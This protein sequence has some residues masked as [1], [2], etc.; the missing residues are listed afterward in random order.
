[1]IKATS[2]KIVLMKF[3]KASRERLVFSPS[4]R[5]CPTLLVSEA[6]SL[7]TRSTKESF[8]RKTIGTAASCSALIMPLK[9]LFVLFLELLVMFFLQLFVHLG[10]TIFVDTNSFKNIDPSPLH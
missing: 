9:V 4:L 7:S 5:F 8:S 1:M 10:Y 2:F 6:L 3:T